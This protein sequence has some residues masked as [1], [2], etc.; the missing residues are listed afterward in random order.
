MHPLSTLALC[1][2][3][4][5]ALPLASNLT[6]VQRLVGFDG[7]GWV[8]GLVLHES[9]GI[10]YARTDVGGA[11]RSDDGGLSWIWLQGWLATREAS[12]ETQGLAVNQSDP[13]GLTV[14]VLIGNQENSVRG[15]GLRN[16]AHDAVQQQKS[17]AIAAC[18]WRLEER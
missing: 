7:G 5:L 14:L 10:I 2:A 6:Y 1:A 17:C 4:A 16:S 8:T 9:T 11:Y 15:A 13:T 3:G 18:N 12:W